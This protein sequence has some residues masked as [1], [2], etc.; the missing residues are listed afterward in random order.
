L[1]YKALGDEDM[2][3]WER[4]MDSLEDFWLSEEADKFVWLLDKSG[5]YT[6]RYMYRRLTFRGADN[7]RMQKPWKSILPNKIE[8]FV[9]LVTQDRLQ[10]GVNLKKKERRG[11]KN[12]C[13]CGIDETSDHICFHCHVARAIRIPLWLRCY[14]IHL[15]PHVL[16]WIKVEFISSSTPIHP[17]TCGLM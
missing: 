6:T 16:G 8:V 15:N 1:E 7:K 11:D 9:W 4:L 3:E 13:L 12:C 2:K 17:S 14:R 10:T 5:N